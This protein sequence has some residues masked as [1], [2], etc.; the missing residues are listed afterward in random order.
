MDENW[1]LLR[2]RPEK[3]VKTTRKDYPGI[4][5]EKRTVALLEGVEKL[6]AK[7]PNAHGYFNSLPFTPKKEYLIWILEARKDET[8][9]RRVSKMI[10]K[11]A[12]GERL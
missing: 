6:L 8:R 4:D 12:L 5:Y 10:E 2:F 1:S 3:L 11:L 7:N 9:E